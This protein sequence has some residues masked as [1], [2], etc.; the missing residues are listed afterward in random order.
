MIACLPA[1]R[2]RPVGSQR[3]AFSHCEE[4]AEGGRRS[5][6]K[7]II[8]FYLMIACL[9]AGRLRLRND[10]KLFSAMYWAVRLSTKVI[11]LYYYC[12]NLFLLFYL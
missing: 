3:R 6:L 4:S 8:L 2:L 11:F 9:P 7:P 5:N 12:F 10:A 1:G